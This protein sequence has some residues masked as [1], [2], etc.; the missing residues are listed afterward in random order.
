MTRLVT[1]LAKRESQSSVI[2]DVISGNRI[3]RTRNPESENATGA[4]Q[5][6]AMTDTTR[7]SGVLPT[8]KCQHETS[9]ISGKAVREQ[10]DTDNVVRELRRGLGLAACMVFVTAQS[11]RGNPESKL[12]GT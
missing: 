4:I 7:G 10:S 11:E 12:Q 6:M 9:P 1:E 2:Q 3:G 8:G 5:D